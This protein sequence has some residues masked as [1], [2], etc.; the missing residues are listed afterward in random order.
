MLMVL[1]VSS[2]CVAAS[3]DSTLDVG[4]GGQRII[5]SGTRSGCLK[6]RNFPQSYPNNIFDEV[7]IPT[8]GFNTFTVFIQEMQVS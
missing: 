5:V 4:D 1:S 6:S 7:T 8:S 3:A 2:P